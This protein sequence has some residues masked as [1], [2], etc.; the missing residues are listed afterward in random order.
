MFISPKTYFP[1][2]KFCR[3]TVNVRCFLKN[4]LFFFF[5][6]CYLLST[7]TGKTVQDSLLFDRHEFTQKFPIFYNFFFSFAF[8]VYEKT[9]IWQCLTQYFHRIQFTWQPNNVYSPHQQKK[10]FW[11]KKIWKSGFLLLSFFLSFYF[12]SLL[13]CVFVVIRFDHFVKL[14][15]QNAVCTWS[16]CRIAVACFNC[17]IR[18]STRKMANWNDR[19]PTITEAATAATAAPNILRCAARKNFKL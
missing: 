8:Y 4:F 17:Y 18:K 14:Q 2:W 11:W 1:I 7:Q 16:L 19:M 15:T 13:L 10:L 6:C 12:L 5:C 9:P 3:K